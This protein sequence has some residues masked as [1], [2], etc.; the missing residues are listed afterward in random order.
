M[1]S[2][3]HILLVFVF[4]IIGFLFSDKLLEIRSISGIFELF[5]NPLSFDFEDE[6]FSGRFLSIFIGLTLVLKYPMGLSFC[7]NDVQVNMDVLGYPTFPHST[8]LYN[9]LT[10]GPLICFYL[11]YNFFK[12]IK[13]DNIL[14]IPIFLYIFLYLIFSGGAFVNFKFIFFIAVFYNLNKTYNGRIHNIT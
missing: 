6:S 1:I 9:Y 14:N 2:F 12:S 10:M 13:F 4:I 5:N 3:K 7:F 11:S 8:L